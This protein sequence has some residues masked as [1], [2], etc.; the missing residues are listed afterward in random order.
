MRSGG[1]RDAWV[2]IWGCGDER[3]TTLGIGL[4]LCLFASD[5]SGHRFGFVFICSSIMVYN[6]KLLLVIR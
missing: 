2:R 3:K 1:I 5:E 6:S 4:V